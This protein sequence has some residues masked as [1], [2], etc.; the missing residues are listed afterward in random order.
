MRTFGFSVLG[1]VGLLL[2]ALPPG[3]AG[4]YYPWCAQSYG[5]SR[6]R[7]CAFDTR[8][9]CMATVSGIGGTCFQNFAPSR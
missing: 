9:Q 4:P 8:D 6:A 2:V 1:L 7:T 5:R 3:E